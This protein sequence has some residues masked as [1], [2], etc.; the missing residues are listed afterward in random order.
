MPLS[1]TIV[2]GRPRRRV[3][4]SS[5]LAKPTPKNDTSAVIPVAPKP[6]IGRGS[7]LDKF[8]EPFQDCWATYYKTLRSTS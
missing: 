6:D 5:L 1:K 4:T 8:L 2:A 7:E 3:S